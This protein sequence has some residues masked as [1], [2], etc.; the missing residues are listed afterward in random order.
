MVGV[1]PQQSL[2]IQLVSAEQKHVSSGSPFKG[3]P[4]RNQ[5]IK[6]DIVLTS[7]GPISAQVGGP[8]PVVREADSQSERPLVGQTGRVNDRWSFEWF[9][10][11][12]HAEL[13]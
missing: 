2:I 1:K 7:V 6:F 8:E 5:S 11:H 13:I 9:I 4:P 10:I 3:A 12:I